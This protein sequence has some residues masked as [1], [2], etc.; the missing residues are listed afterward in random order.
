M[1]GLSGAGETVVLN[2]LLAA[3]FVSLHTSDP[4]N[5]GTAEVAGDTYIR[6]AGTFV[7][8][9]NNPTVAANNAPIQFPTAGAS[10]GNIT[11][12]GLW[13]AATAGTFLGGW[14]VTTPKP[15]NIEDTVRWD[16]GQLKIGTDE[17]AV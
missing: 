16:T 7:N 8:S 14:P 5:T 17:L 3:R 6:Q 13:S 11:H 1:A 12:F 9:G 10:W 2:A 15:V 4:G